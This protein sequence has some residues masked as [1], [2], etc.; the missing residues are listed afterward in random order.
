MHLALNIFKLHIPAY[1]LLLI[2]T[3]FSFSDYSRQGLYDRILEQAKLLSIPLY[4]KGRKKTV[5]AQERPFTR[6]LPTG[7]SS[8]ENFPGNS[9]V[10]LSLFRT[11]ITEEEL[12]VYTSRL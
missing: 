9:R 7:V 10:V 3:L 8:L 12:E 2:L 11:R 1:A 4:R 5:S 6:T